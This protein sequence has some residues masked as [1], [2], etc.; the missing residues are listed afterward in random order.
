VRDDV[1]K[2]IVKAI[3]SHYIQH[4][5]LVQII[6][7]YQDTNNEHSN[8]SQSQLQSISYELSKPLRLYFCG[9]SL[10]AALAVLAALDVSVNMNYIVDAIKTTYENASHNNIGEIDREG[11]PNHSDVGNFVSNKHENQNDHDMN[12]SQKLK[13]GLSKKSEGYRSLGST[14]VSV[15]RSFNETNSRASKGFPCDVRWEV[16]TLAVYTY[17]GE[18]VGGDYASHFNVLLVR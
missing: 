8:I 9:H 12:N 5:K 16:P 1:L 13:V 6:N 18:V 14:D 4:N 2:S 17:G 10:G 7:Q 3:N 15:N 11:I